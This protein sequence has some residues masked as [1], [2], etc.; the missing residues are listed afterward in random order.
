MS[1]ATTTEPAWKALDTIARSKRATC[2]A[3]QQARKDAQAAEKAAF[4]AW[5]TA[6]R[7]DI[8][9]LSGRRPP[10]DCSV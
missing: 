4:K 7:D 8:E 1:T 10:P 6:Q 3:A 9:A 2:L 5:D